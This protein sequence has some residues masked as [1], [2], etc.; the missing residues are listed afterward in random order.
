MKLNLYNNENFKENFDFD[1][2]TIR[3][4]SEMVKRYKQA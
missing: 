2:S 1:V 3:G 4:Y